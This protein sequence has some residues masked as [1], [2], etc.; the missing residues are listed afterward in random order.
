MIIAIALLSLCSILLVGA[1]VIAWKI[2]KSFVEK[3]RSEQFFL[4]EI[5][6]S[7]DFLAATLREVSEEKKDQPFVVKK[8]ETNWPNLKRSFTPWGGGNERSGT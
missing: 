8:T 4:K 1:H 6:E 2:Y 7:I 5:S 3:K